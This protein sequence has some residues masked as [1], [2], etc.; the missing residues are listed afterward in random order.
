MIHDTAQDNLV[1]RTAFLSF[2]FILK[3]LTEVNK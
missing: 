1:F 3:T 2:Y